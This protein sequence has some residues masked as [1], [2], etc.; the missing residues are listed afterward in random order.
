LQHY[1]DVSPLEGTNKR[2][3]SYVSFSKVTVADFVASAA[4]DSGVTEMELILP[5]QCVSRLH[6]RLRENEL[7]KAE[8]VL[9]FFLAC[10]VGNPLDVNSGRHDEVRVIE[11]MVIE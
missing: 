1:A 6:E 8:E 3:G 4:P 5:L 7:P 9:D 2:F 11:V 10:F